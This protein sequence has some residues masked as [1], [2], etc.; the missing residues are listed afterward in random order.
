MLT[1]G[2]NFKAT[3]NQI[4][5]ECNKVDDENHRLNECLLWSDTNF[6]ENVIKPKFNDIFS[7]NDTTLNEII[8]KIEHVW[9]LKYA[10]GRMKISWSWLTYLFYLLYL[11]MNHC[12]TERS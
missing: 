8:E 4:C 3:M 1:C 12:N 11:F 9:E 2:R 7:E 5:K 6:R 10:N